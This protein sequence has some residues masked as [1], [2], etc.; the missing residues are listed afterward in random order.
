MKKKNINYEADKRRKR[1]QQIT[2]MLKEVVQ[3][4]NVCTYKPQVTTCQEPQCKTRQELKILRLA[5]PGLRVG[6]SSHTAAFQGSSGDVEKQ[7]RHWKA[8]RGDLKS[9]YGVSPMPWKS[10][11]V[12]ESKAERFAPHRL[13]RTGKCLWEAQVEELR[14]FQCLRMRNLVLVS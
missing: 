2:E 13:R 8:Q 7:N 9:V 11:Q 6:N 14:L 4:E 12:C 3:R 10:S 5:S 1:K